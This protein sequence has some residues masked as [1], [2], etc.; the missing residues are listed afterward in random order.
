MK[1]A[2][3][4]LTIDDEEPIRR[5]IRVYFEDLG[6]EVLEAGNGSA[7]LAMV[8][9][10]HPDLV[11]VDLRMPGMSGLE[12]IDALVKDSPGTPVVVLSGT[13][14][15]G[16]AI[17]AI[18]RGAWDYVTKPIVDLAQLEHVVDMALERARLREERRRYRD[19]LEEE[20]ARRTQELRDLNERL[21]KMVRSARTIASCTSL[22]TLGRRL[23]E[24][25]A[26]VLGAE[27]GSL[28]L[29]EDGK[30]SL[31][32][33]LDPGHAKETIPMPPPPDSVL[34][35]AVERK[36]LI[37]TDDIQAATSMVPSGWAGYRNGSLMAIPLLDGRAQ[38]LGAL[39]LHNKSSPPFTD[40]DLEIVGMLAS[41]SSEA[42]RAVRATEQLRESE[43]NLQAVIESLPG[44]FFM[45]DDRGKLVRWNRESER[46]G[47]Y[48]P[49]EIERMH[50]EQY[51][52]EEDQPTVRRAMADV[53]RD[54]K[55]EV[56]A[57]YRTKS[58]Q[59]IP[60]YLVGNRQ[61]LRDR[62]YLVGF[63]ID[64]TTRR[65][66]EEQ[67]L[68]AQ[69]MEAV[70]T[71]AGGVAHDFNNL[72]QVMSGYAELALSQLEPSS[73]EADAIR[74]V[75][76]AGER[77]ATLVGQLLVFS[78]RQVMR[79]ESLDLNSVVAELL[80]M[81]QRII[82]EHIRLRFIPG[83]DLGTVQ[84]DRGMMEQ[85]LMNLCVNARDAMPEGGDL[86][87]ET[88][89]AM[90]EPSKWERHP[91]VEPGP[92]V[93]ICVTDTGV[94]MS[95]EIRQRIFEPF[96]TTKEKGKGTGLGLAAVFGIVKLH[97][98]V[99]TCESELG[100]GTRFEILLPSQ[101]GGAVAVGAEEETAGPGGSETILLAEDDEMVRYLTAELLK[102]AGY[103]VLCARDGEEAQALFLE[104]AQRIDLLMLDVVMPRV[105]GREVYEWARS[106]RPEIAAVFCS[107][108]AE[109]EVHKAFIVE[110]GL[111]L[112]RKP[113][114]YNQLLGT[115]RRVL[116]TS[117]AVPPGEG[118]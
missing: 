80:R 54:G 79:P 74:H 33:T 21:K 94:G 116:D 30:L 75:I 86:T 110:R 26:S 104:H 44:M 46:I 28:Y 45:V 39:T 90:I 105:G 88:Y 7:G 76:S 71:L 69:K 93:R 89:R 62:D 41:Y 67:L 58:G 40:Q 8:R 112:L 84:A 48:S 29:N 55:A 16:D 10:R 118:S 22:D 115:V 97:C 108:Y 13:G 109:G 59:V 95:Q 111:E 72:L 64:I 15:I 31:I 73:R 63:G 18:R 100:K 56:E 101:P 53:F 66:L 5:S 92:H 25:F 23:L 34:G 78:R 99:I 2:V 11:L 82:G 36:T 51:F 87:I 61:R 14:V 6:Y 35:R 77:A 32:H 50:P 43:A 9:E 113:F 102:G 3:R 60:F 83:E 49:D 52:V 107:G 4:L 12:V 117:R 47:G 17:D 98:G 27:G 38:L 85:V 37:V 70:G 42:I 103:T 114:K 96:F 19:R 57:R 81:V 91:E 20:V 24:E 106:I 65:E 68:Q 1:P